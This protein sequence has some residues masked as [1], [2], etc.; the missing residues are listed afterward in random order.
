M[1]NLQKRKGKQMSR[2]WT[3]CVA[4][5]SAYNASENICI[6]KILRTSWY[7]M[8]KT[9]M[10]EMLPKSQACFA[11]AGRGYKASGLRLRDEGLSSK[12]TVIDMRISPFESVPLVQALVLMQR[13]SNRWLHE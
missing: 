2:K 11:D 12:C 13:G 4:G 9:E 10:P 8:S 1:P 5:N 7:D 3:P 6:P